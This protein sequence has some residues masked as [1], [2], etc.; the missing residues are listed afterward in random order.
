MPLECLAW[1]GLNSLLAFQRCSSLQFYP[2]SPAPF[3]SC[4]ALALCIRFTRTNPCEKKLKI[5]VQSSPSC[6]NSAAE[7]Q[8]HVNWP[9]LCCRL[10]RR[11]HASAPCPKPPLSVPWLGI[12]TEVA[13]KCCKNPFLFAFS[14]WFVT[15]SLCCF[16]SAPDTPAA[17]ASSTAPSVFYLLFAWQPLSRA[18]VSFA[19][20]TPTPSTSAKECIWPK[21]AGAWKLAIRMLLHFLEMEAGIETIHERCGQTRNYA[22]SQLVRVITFSFFLIQNLFPEIFVLNDF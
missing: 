21:N 17:P 11:C 1:L 7:T 13:K 9:I 20:P 16:R 4:Q 15:G 10:P 19:Q 12:R 2:P 14:F 3:C 18:P 6:N 8:T 5:E 22:P